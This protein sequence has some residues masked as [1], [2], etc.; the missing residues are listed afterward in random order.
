V[1]V[2]GKTLRGGVAAREFVVTT[3][4]E[5]P[6]GA[7][8]ARFREKARRLAGVVHAA[9][10]TDNQSARVRLSPLG[11]ALALLGEGIDPIMQLTCRDRNRLAL[12]SDLLAASALGVRQ[13]LALYGDPIKIGDHPEAKD[14]FDVDTNGLLGLVGALNSGKDSTGNALAGPTDL[15]A[16]AAASPDNPDPAKVEGQVQGFVKKLAAGARFFQTQAVYSSE[17]VAGFMSRPEV[18]A[19]GAP[20]LAGIMVLKSAKMARFVQEKIPG[21]FVPDPLIAELERSSSPLETGI[22]IA[23]RQVRE[24][25]GIVQG[26]HLYTMGLEERVPEI[27]ERAGV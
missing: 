12:Q 4:F 7:D 15:W 2:P 11:G 21:I 5:P 25:R 10:V 16:G 26:V 19:S 27:L 1:A 3:E 6:K 22:E 20:V 8:L 13:V 23:A 17:R 24:L 18:K 9:N 14:V